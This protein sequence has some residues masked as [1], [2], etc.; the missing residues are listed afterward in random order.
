VTR[1]E[2]EMMRSLVLEVAGR[3]H[4]DHLLAEADAKYTEA[5]FRSSGPTASAERC[6]GTRCLRHRCTP[7]AA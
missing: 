4:V 7:G 3:H 5:P 6:D 2:T 1:V